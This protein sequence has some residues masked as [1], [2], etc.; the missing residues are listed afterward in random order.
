MRKNTHLLPPAVVALVTSVALA[1]C[2]ESTDTTAGPDQG[3][4]RQV[5]VTLNHFYNALKQADG[6]AAC[7]LIADDQRD[8]IA[9]SVTLDPRTAGSCARSF[10]SFARKARREGSLLPRTPV[11]VHRVKVE[12]DKAKATVSVGDGP[13]VQVPLGREDGEWRVREIR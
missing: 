2:A 11:R 10:A 6:R 9:E 4:A 12:G 13:V 3:E 5:T 7:A 8:T 1:G